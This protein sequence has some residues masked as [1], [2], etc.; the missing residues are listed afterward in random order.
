MQAEPSH[1]EGRNAPNAR[2]AV[3]AA[4]SGPRWTLS[5][6]RYDAIDVE[7]LR[8]ETRLFQLVAA[9]SFVEIT[10][11]LYT[12]NLVDYYRGDED[13]V[14]WLEDG[15]QREEVQHGAA[16]RPYVE[17]A[18]PDFD[19][20]RAYANFLAEYSALCAIERFAGTRA[21]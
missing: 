10:S 15:W 8:G 19:W 11:E 1:A 16:L 14:A 21:L 3:R 12:R 13:L 4:R 9:A 2:R 17:T 18:W 7:R 5:D 20:G 6:I